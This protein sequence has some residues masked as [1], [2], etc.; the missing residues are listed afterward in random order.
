MFTILK[1]SFAALAAIA[2]AGGL[3]YVT[4][5]EFGA[6]MSPE[7]LKRF[8]RSPN[9]I[10]GHFVNTDPVPASTPGAKDAPKVSMLSWFF[11]VVMPPD[12]K[13][14][15]EPLPSV[16]FDPVRAQRNIPNDA[17]I[18]WLGHSGVVLHLDGET[19][20]VDPVVKRASPLPVT[21]KPFETVVPLEAWML[22]QVI[23]AMLISHDHYDHLEADTIR[24]L[25]PRVSQFY[26]PLG[27]GEHLK[28]WGIAPDRITELDWDE[29]ARLGGLRVT[30]TE[31]RHFSGRTFK[32]R[33][34]TLW[35]GFVVEGSQK[36]YFS[37]DGGYGAHF[38]RIGERYGPFDFAFIENGAYNAAWAGIHMTPEETLSAAVDVGAKRV[39]PVHWGRFDLAFHPW[40]EPVERLIK[41]ARVRPDITIVTPVIGE[42]FLTSD[43]PGMTERWWRRVK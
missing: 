11:S 43:A 4:T 40:T 37:G 27:V 19:I 23:D 36:F 30:L 14:P 42:S 2:A 10:N 12:G 6:E 28:R 16:R 26:C 18:T 7:A 21:G 39:M 15:A 29:T 5:D 25:A 3:W 34:T 1:W 33:D 31:S 41:A 32:G 17:V 24:F 20:V 9:Y 35:G 38:A 13:Q 8:E 22:P